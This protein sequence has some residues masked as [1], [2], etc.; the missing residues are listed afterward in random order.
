MYSRQPSNKKPMKKP[1]TTEYAV[2][3]PAQPILQR[4][5][6]LILVALSTILLLLIALLCFLLIPRSLSMSVLPPQKESDNYGI[7]SNNGLLSI[8]T[9]AII[10]AKIRNR[11]F[12]SVQLY[13]VRMSFSWITREVSTLPDFAATSSSLDAKL[14]P[15]STQEV[16]IPLDFLYNGDIN[17]DPLVQDFL[18]RCFTDNRGLD[19]VYVAEFEL[20][21]MFTTRKTQASRVKMLLPCPMSHRLISDTLSQLNMTLN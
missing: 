14:P 10:K 4:H 3:V 8:N 2:P 5:W 18:K 13:S 11:N 16:S 6:K 19:I 12:Y 17:S 7:T 1:I 21:H 9:S 15:R 20:S